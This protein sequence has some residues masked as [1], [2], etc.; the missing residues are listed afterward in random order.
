MD[1]NVLFELD[2]DIVEALVSIERIKDMLAEVCEG[3]F[4]LTGTR[5]AE[6]IALNFEHTRICAEIARDYAVQ[7]KQTLD[8]VCAVIAQNIK[9]AAPAGNGPEVAA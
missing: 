7:S 2:A 4:C 3:F 6:A 1:K 5:R 9:D 8:D